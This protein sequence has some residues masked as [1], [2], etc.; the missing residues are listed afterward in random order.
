MQPFKLLLLG[1]AICFLSLPHPA[2]ALSSDR[3]EPI[4][5]EADSATLHEKSGNSTY[6]GNVHLRQG[7]LHLTGDTMTVEMRDDRIEKIV[8]TGSPATYVQRPDNSDE[9]QHAR[10]GRV[11]YYATEERLILLENAHIWQSGNEEFSSERIIFNLADNTVNAGGGGSGDRVRITLQ[12]RK[13]ADT[14]AEP[15]PDPEPQAEPDAALEA[16][17]AETPSPDIKP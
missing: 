1:C 10:A 15:G 11:E 2:W 8:L 17:P 16:V 3:D 5:I 14:E 4:N 6:R 9:D 12:P 13:S 7:T